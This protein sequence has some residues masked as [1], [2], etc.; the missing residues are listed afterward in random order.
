MI[1][2]SICLRRVI[3]V[4]ES[5]SV[6][7]IVVGST[8]AAA[9]GV[10]RMTRDVDVVAVIPSADVEYLVESLGRTEFYIPTEDA[11]VA[12]LNGGAF[13]VLHPASGG[14]VDLF[15]VLA[16]DEFTASRL[17]RR[18]RSNVLGVDTWIASPEDV[19]LA[20]LRWRQASRSEVHWRDC[21][22]IAATQSLDVSYLRT[23][24]TR[25]GIESDLEQLLEGV[26]NPL[27]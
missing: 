27:I 16:D 4:L 21:V 5:R 19:V 3:E 1:D 11:R 8:A 13:N 7:Y 18:I 2:L 15:V 9:W 20:K 24:G 12:G 26:A 10:A 22:E 17:Q 6:P 23:W 25:L 14:K